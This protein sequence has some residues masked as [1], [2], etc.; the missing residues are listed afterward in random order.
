[1]ETIGTTRMGLLWSFLG[2]EN[3]ILSG[4]E[5][6]GQLLLV[7]CPHRTVQQKT[8]LLMHCL[9]CHC[10]HFFYCSTKPNCKIW[11]LIHKHHFIIYYTFHGQLAMHLKPKIY[12]FIANLP[13]KIDI[14]KP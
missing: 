10:T 7:L 14:I 12:V 3:H 13:T 6:S 8:Q 11:L 2:R 5:G 9:G 1:M 4:N